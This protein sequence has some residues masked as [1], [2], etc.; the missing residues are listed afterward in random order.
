MER[1]CHFGIPDAVEDTFRKL[2]GQD[3]MGGKAMVYCISGPT[4]WLIVMIARNHSS[5]IQKPN[6][7]MRWWRCTSKLGMQKFPHYMTVVTYTQKNVIVPFPLAKKVLT[8]PYLL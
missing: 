2:G 4:I 5:K 3:E 7:N 1:V 8:W 6:A